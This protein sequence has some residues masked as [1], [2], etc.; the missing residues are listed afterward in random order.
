VAPEVAHKLETEEIRVPQKDVR[1]VGKA[2]LLAAPEQK[3]QIVSELKEDFKT[4]TITA[5]KI[6]A[7]SKPKKPSSVLEASLDDHVGDIPEVTLTE[8]NSDLEAFLEL[9]GRICC[10]KCGKCALRALKWSCCGFSID[11][12]SNRADGVENESTSLVSMAV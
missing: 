2:L 4:A 9:A 8:S 12:A 3:E 6:T 5:K 10:P 7:Q 1:A 11:E